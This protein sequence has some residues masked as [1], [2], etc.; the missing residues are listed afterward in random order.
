MVL[1]VLAEG[2]A[3]PLRKRLPQALP[4]LLSA[5]SDQASEVRGAAA[6]AVSQFAEWLQP[7]V[8]Q[9]YKALIPGVFTLLRDPHKDVQER[10]CYGE[11]TVLMAGSEC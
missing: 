3:E 9:H 6:F 5:L 7:D 10:A 8:L 11:Q 4:L 2:C 1:A